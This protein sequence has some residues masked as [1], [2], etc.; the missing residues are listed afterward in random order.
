MYSFKSP[1]KLLHR[2]KDCYVKNRNDDLSIM[3][4]VEIY[5]ENVEEDGILE[6]LKSKFH[7]LGRVSIDSESFR[8]DVENQEFRIPVII[9]SS[10]E[11]ENLT[12]IRFNS[13]DTPWG[14]DSECAREA[15]EFFQLPVLC[16][17]GPENPLPNLFLRITVSGESLVDVDERST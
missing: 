9:H 14:S 1:N 10:V 7:L 15:F 5:I 6:W 12:S 13:E 8:I 3:A 4:D 11:G 16:D 17:P 2:K